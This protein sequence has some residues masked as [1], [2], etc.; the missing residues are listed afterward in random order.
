M[1]VSSIEV[2]CSGKTQAVAFSDGETLLAALRNAGFSLPAACGGRGKCGKC[3]VRINGV[4]RLACRA[5]P[6]EGDVVELPETAGGAI[7]TATVPVAPPAPVGA[8]EGIAAAVDLGTTTV[9]VRIY[10]LKTAAELTT[11]SA[12]NA[13]AP[14]G[15]DVLSRIRY[16]MDSSNG[17]HELSAIIRRQTASRA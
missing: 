12:W 5:A 13:Q 17:L 11:R 7:L 2:R 3:R 1:A 15:G 9:A 6:V 14:Y 10:D 8:Q 16:T 4:Q